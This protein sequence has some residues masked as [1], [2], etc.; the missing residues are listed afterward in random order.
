M[1]RSEFEADPEGYRLE[2]HQKIRGRLS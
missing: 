2:R 1:T